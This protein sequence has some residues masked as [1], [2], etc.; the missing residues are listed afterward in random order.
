M[1]D[2]RCPPRENA[3]IMQS[4]GL[5][6]W[7]IRRINSVSSSRTLH[8]LCVRMKGHP[9]KGPE[10]VY[11]W[12]QIE[13]SLFNDCSQLVNVFSSGSLVKNVELM[14]WCSLILFS[15]EE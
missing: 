1:V 9:G 11:W 3:N 14:V 7:W 13:F 2:K 15:L 6:M 4:E 5:I 12:D 8:S 10:G